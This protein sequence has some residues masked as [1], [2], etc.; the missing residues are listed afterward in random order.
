MAEGGRLDDLCQIQNLPEFFRATFP[1][2]ELKEVSDFQRLLVHELISELSGFSRHMSGPGA[3]L[4]D[5]TLIRFQVENMKVLIRGY[6]KQTPMEEMYEHLVSLPKGLAFDNQKMATART[7]DDLVRLFPR[8][9]LLQESMKK[10]VRVYS[11]HSQPFFFEAMLDRAYFQG[12]LARMERL[13]RE[14]LEAI[15]PVVHQEVD[16][17]HIMLAARGRF[18][19]NLPPE[20]LRPLHVAGTRIPLSLFATILD[21]PDLLTS[22]GRV[23]QRVIDGV[24]L[25]KGSSDKPMVNDASVLDGLVW[26]RLFRLANRAF[27]QS[28]I[29]LGAVIGYA[30]L[31]RIE[32]ANLITISEGI[33]GGFS[34]GSIRERL[35]PRADVEG[36]YV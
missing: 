14:D 5:W 7:L 20:M 30:V 29:G 11:D 21:D 17:F 18:N 1:E 2:S 3:D 9:G 32:V 36:A 19:Y 10:A 27:R 23:I 26:K 22:A 24:P 28:H 25:E 8:G 35:T 4:I 33:R 15:R 16:I 31:R 6:L 12:L 34:A 13:A